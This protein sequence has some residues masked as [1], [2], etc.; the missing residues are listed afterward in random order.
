[1]KSSDPSERTIVVA[2]DHPLVR[3][4]VVAT[5]GTSADYRIV[6]QAKDSFET[7]DLITREKPWL[8]LL[9]LQMDG[10]PS[11]R[12]IQDCHESHPSLK[13]LILSAHLDPRYLRPLREARIEGFL[14][15]DEAPDS[16]LQALRVLDSGATWFSHAVL[17]QVMSISEAER[18]QDGPKLT[19]REQQVF[20]LMMQAK[21]NQTIAD[22]LKVSKQTV[23]RYATVIYEKLGVKSRVEAIVKGS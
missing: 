22:E 3:A 21:D 7:L 13:V 23:R 19:A 12:L 9:D 11:E 1:L 10:Y 15:K 5:L 2:D 17:Q 6:G 8:L 20:D 18:L 14:L 16:L 4:G